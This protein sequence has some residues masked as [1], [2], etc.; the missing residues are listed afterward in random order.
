MI[1]MTDAKVVAEELRIRY[2]HAR[3]VTLVGRTIQKALFGGRPDE[4]IFWTLVYAHYCGGD[5]NL[6]IDQQ[7][8]AFAPFILRDR[9]ASGAGNAGRSG[10]DATVTR[11]PLGQSFD[12]R[13][14]E[15][16]SGDAVYQVKAFTELPSRPSGPPRRP[17][18]FE[19]FARCR[20]APA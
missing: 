20:L 5:L 3:A 18:R 6:V 1:R 11:F 8:E 17:R 7:L 12:M 19:P 2:E 9:H 10:I 13:D 15:T 14:A 16:E 4:A